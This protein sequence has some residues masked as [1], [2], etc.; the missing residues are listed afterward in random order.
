MKFKTKTIFFYDAGDTMEAIKAQI[1]A[2]TAQI[3]ELKNKD[4]E[5]L[6][7]I[8]ENLTNTVE[9]LQDDLKK[10]LEVKP[11]PPVVEPPKPPVVEPPKPKDDEMPAWYKAEMKRLA[12]EKL[13]KVKASLVVEYPDYAEEINLASTEAEIE[14]LI[15]TIKKVKAK[16]AEMTDEKLLALIKEK[17]EDWQ[18]Q[19]GLSYK[20]KPKENKDDKMKSFFEKFKQ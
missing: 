19:Q 6:K 11:K 7:G 1:D 18:N 10:A 4:D 16:E 8:I 12:E 5:G 20:K 2:L 13:A 17:G 14:R 3:E 9:K 15:G